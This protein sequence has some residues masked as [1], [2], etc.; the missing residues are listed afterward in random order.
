MHYGVE[1]GLPSAKEAAKAYRDDPDTDFHELVGEMT[2]LGRDNGQDREFRQGLRLR[3]GDV[4]QDDR[5]VAGGSGSHHGAI[6]R[7]AAVR[8]EAVSHRA[9]EGVP[10]RHHPAL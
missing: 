6:R 4:R 8:S 2:G 10:H 3:R 5:Q 9:G 7:Q 1:R